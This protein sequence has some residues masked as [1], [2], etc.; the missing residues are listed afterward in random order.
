ME[1]QQVAIAVAIFNCSFAFNLLCMFTDTGHKCSEK[2][3][4]ILKLKC[5]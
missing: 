4:E 5:F 1:K 3:A 2:D